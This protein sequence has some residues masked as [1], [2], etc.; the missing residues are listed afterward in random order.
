MGADYR[1]RMAGDLLAAPCN[2]GQLVG[3]APPTLTNSSVAHSAKI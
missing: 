1:Y 3:R 2:D